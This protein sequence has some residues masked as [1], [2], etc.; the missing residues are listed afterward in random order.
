MKD[1][2]G[3]NGGTIKR[4]E[5]GDPP[6]PGAGRPEGARS[7]KTLL[8]EALARTTNTNDG[9]KIEIKEASAIQLI[10]ILLSPETDDN[11]KL[12]AFQIIR[13]T[14]GESPINKMEHSGEIGGETAFSALP[15]EKRLAIWKILNDGDEPAIISDGSE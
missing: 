13:D 6:L 14:I 9:R 7:Y 5:K 11:T 3:R 15:L 12:K 2:P 1:V 4:M 10:A 8:D